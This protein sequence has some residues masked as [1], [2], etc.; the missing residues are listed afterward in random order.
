[1][2][3]CASGGQNKDAKPLWASILIAFIETDLSFP[4]V[5]F[6][7]T[8]DRFSRVIQFNEEVQDRIPAPELQNHIRALDV[9]PEAKPSIV[10]S[11]KTQQRYAAFVSCNERMH[12]EVGKGPS[13][14]LEAEGNRPEKASRRERRAVPIEQSVAGRCH[15]IV[16]LKSVAGAGIR[17]ATHPASIS[18]D[19][20]SSPEWPGG[21][22][23]LLECRAQ[24][25]Q[26]G[27]GERRTADCFEY[28]SVAWCTL[29]MH[30]DL[31]RRIVT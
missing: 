6:L 12:E 22:K 11:L 29:C 24:T 17:P 2:A 16:I 31:W 13:V 7:A 23:R 19:L 20:H 4:G 8:E 3:N 1:M 9:I 30:C 14:F 10:F 18:E 26:L 25:E 21:R 15:L 28:F 27:R 5:T